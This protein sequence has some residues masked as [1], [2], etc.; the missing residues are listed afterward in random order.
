MSTLSIQN[1]SVT[2]GGLTAVNQ[3]SFS[4]Q[5]SEM[6]AVIGPNGAGK[7]TLFNLIT[8]VYSPSGGDVVLDE[9]SLLHYS[10]DQINRLGLARTFQNIR[11]FP[12]LTVEENILV[13][14]HVVPG[15]WQGFIRPFQTLK[16][17][18]QL[19]IEA[20]QLLSLYGLSAQASALAGSL[21]YGEQRKLEILR[22][23]ATKPKFLLLDDPAAGMNASEKNELAGLIRKT[24]EQFNLGIVLI[25]HDM[26][27][28]MN[29]VPRILVLDYGVTIAEGSPKEISSHPKVIEA[30]LGNEETCNL[31]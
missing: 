6:M 29:L 1:I 24:Q 16:E 30:Y 21:S 23:L 10:P 12:Q 14:N 18:T 25:E 28:V 11:L 7:T 9:K 2:F 5:S 22:A 8:G 26:K 27:F 13:A 4:L 31:K 15:L 3:V 17:E 20:A 19:R